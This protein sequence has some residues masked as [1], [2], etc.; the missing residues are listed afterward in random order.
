MK[1]VD[2]SR[3]PELATPP[4]L[5]MGPGPSQVDPRVLRAMATPLLGHLD[6]HF[7]GLMD[8][9]QE[10]LRYVFETRNPLTIPVSGTGS[11]AMEA[12]IANLVEPGDPVLVCVN[13]YF[14]LR[15]ADMAAR[16]GGQVQTLVRPWGDGV[17]P[18]R[19]ARGAG[20]DPGPHR[21]DRARRDL[22]RRET[23]PRRD[24]PGRP[25]SRRP[26]DR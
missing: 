7:V 12:A 19:S 6:P 4:R 5:L 11:A 21:R 25:R 20:E 26:A 14:G 15:L 9:V 18:I 1:P 10:L 17:R 3:F 13:G 16:Y 23:T 8:Q 2:M 22:D 24:C